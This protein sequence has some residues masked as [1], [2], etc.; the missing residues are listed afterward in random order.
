MDNTRLEQR[1]KELKQ[2][3]LQYNWIIE[4]LLDDPRRLTETER[5]RFTEENIIKIN[6]LQ[7]I[8]KEIRDIEW[9]LMGPE[10]QQEYIDKYKED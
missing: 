3:R 1:L 4:K 9:E 5:V 10:K 8:S 2:Q 6:E 7:L